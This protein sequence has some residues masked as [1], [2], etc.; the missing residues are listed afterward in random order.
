VFVSSTWQREIQI[1]SYGTR[2]NAEEPAHLAAPPLLFFQSQ[3]N[4]Q[5][6]HCKCVS[7]I[8]NPA[9]QKLVE[10]L[11]QRLDVPNVAKFENCRCKGDALQGHFFATVDKSGNYEDIAIQQLT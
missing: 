2:K 9:F 5:I 11:R 3:L 6:Q 1:L 10:H 8:R 7:G 4:E